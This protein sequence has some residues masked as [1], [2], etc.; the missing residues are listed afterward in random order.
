[1]KNPSLTELLQLAQQHQRRLDELRENRRM[2]VGWSDPLFHKAKLAWEDLHRAMVE[3]EQFDLVK[4]D[5]EVR[6]VKTVG[7]LRAS[8]Y[9]SYSEKKNTEEFIFTINLMRVAS[10]KPTQNITPRNHNV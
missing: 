5:T 4:F 9:V 7:P 6:Q 8:H 1:M 10:I 3:A 2:R